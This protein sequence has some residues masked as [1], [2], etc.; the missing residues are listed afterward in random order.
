MADMMAKQIKLIR[1]MSDTSCNLSS[2][3]SKYTGSLDVQTDTKTN[4]ENEV[5]MTPKTLLFM[6]NSIKSTYQMYSEKTSVQKIII[7]DEI[8]KFVINMN[9]RTE[10]INMMISVIKL[11]FKKLM[12]KRSSHLEHEYKVEELF[13]ICEYLKYQQEFVKLLFIK[14]HL[15]VVR[16]L[17]ILSGSGPGQH[18]GSREHGQEIITEYLRLKE[19]NKKLAQSKSKTESTSI[20]AQKW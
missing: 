11:K 2:A 20:L 4:D 10:D 14:F 3:F 17:G 13:R 8:S 7:E 19:E 9:T 1:L 18:R 16:Y 12:K 6:E 15:F 5:N